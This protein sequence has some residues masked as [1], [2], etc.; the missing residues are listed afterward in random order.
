[1][2]ALQDSSER[3]EAA[4]ARLEAVLAERAGETGELRAAIAEARA[5]NERLQKL[6]GE[7]ANR[8][9]RTIAELERVMKEA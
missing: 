7:A 1:M 6:A 3:L 9:D 8:L 5:E 4:L 2:S